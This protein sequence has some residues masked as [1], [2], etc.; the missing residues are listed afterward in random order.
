MRSLHAFVS[1]VLVGCIDPSSIDAAGKAYAT[2]LA[3]VFTLESSGSGLGWYLLDTNGP[4][5]EISRIAA[6]RVSVAAH[7][8]AI[9]IQFEV[10]VYKNR[11]DT[12][13]VHATMPVSELMVGDRVVAFA[14]GSFGRLHDAQGDPVPHATAPGPLA[15]LLAD[16][17][18]A[19]NALRDDPG[20]AVITTERRV[21]GPAARATLATLPAMTIDSVREIRGTNWGVAQA[22]LA[23]EVDGKTYR[24]SGQLIALYEDDRWSVV[25]VHYIAL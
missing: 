10:G 16:P 11:W 15:A 8:N 1:L 9:A 19:A 3:E 4:G 21:I 24:V 12:G 22:H 17:A 25:S 6:E 7:G 5:W 20:I 14:A 23:G 2:A 13:A 18:R